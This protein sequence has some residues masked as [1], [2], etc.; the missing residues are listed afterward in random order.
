MKRYLVTVVIIIIIIII[1][2]INPSNTTNNF[3]FNDKHRLHI[4]TYPK[5]SSGQV[6]TQ[7]N[8]YILMCV[9]IMGSNTAYNY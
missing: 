7:S 6:F 8:N 1:I 9:R 5:P 4:S 3:L 2:I